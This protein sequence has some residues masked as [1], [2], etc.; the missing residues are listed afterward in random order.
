MADGNVQL[1]AGSLSYA[2]WKEVQVQLPAYPNPEK[3]LRFRTTPINFNFFVDADSVSVASDGVV[4]FTLLARSSSGA[5]N[6]TFEG[7]RCSSRQRRTYAFGRSDKT[8]SKA[9]DNSWKLFG[10]AAGVP[11]YETL[12]VD[13]FCPENSIIPDAKAALNALRWGSRRDFNR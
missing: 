3:L 6:V 12:A 5:E 2:G 9:R 4:R 13:Y 8:W 7:M 10:A 11:Q 1:L